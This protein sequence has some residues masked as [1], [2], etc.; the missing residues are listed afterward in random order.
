M[1]IISVRKP[2]I[3]LF[4]VCLSHCAWGLFYNNEWMYLIILWPVTKMDSLLFHKNK[5]L[6]FPSG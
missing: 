1:Q 4:C 6:D 5:K 2:D 3:A